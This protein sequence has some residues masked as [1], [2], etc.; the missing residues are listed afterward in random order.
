MKWLD[1]LE[2]KYGRYY[3][4]NL[5]LKVILLSTI[6][7]FITFYII[8]DRNYINGLTLDRA[9]IL[10]GEVWRLFSFIF[11]PPMNNSLIIVA[12]Y[13]YFDYLAGVNLEHEWGEFKFNIYFLFGMIGTIIVSFITG[14]PATGAYVSTSIFLAFA[15]L[16]PNFVVYV[17]FIL[18]VKMKWIGYFT[19]SGIILNFVLRIVGGNI[20][21]AFLVV[22]PLINYFLFF[23]VGNYKSAKMRTNS[24]IRKI[25]YDKAFKENKKAYRHKCTVCGI[26]DADDKNMLFRY[27]SKCNGE[28]AY[29]EKHIKNHEHIK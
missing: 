12:L 16:F 23:G 11:I 14:V 19:W 6:V 8:Q 25:E 15:K 26:T 10:K 13:L 24:K 21:S 9:R 4:P 22:I 17:F 1:K 7:Y 29:C 28:H 27:C 18:P 3:I 20:M 5:M 2:R